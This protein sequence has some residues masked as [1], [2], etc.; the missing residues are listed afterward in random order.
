MSLKDMVCRMF[1]CI[2]L[3]V[4]YALGA[5]CGVGLFFGP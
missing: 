3:L 1:L 5:V 2:E 4:W